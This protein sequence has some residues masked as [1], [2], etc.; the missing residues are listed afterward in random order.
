MAVVSGVLADQQDDAVTPPAG[1]EMYR[2][3]RSR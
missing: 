1:I 3:L 2:A